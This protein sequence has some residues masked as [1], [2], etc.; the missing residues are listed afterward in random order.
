MESPPMDPLERFLARFDP[1]GASN[2]PSGRGGGAKPSQGQAP[3]YPPP[4]ATPPPGALPPAA[5]PIY[6]PPGGGYGPGHAPGAPPIHPQ[7]ASRAGASGWHGFAPATPQARPGAS[8]VHSAHGAEGFGSEGSPQ[9]PSPGSS[10]GR[11]STAT[12]HMGARIRDTARARVLGFAGKAAS[13]AT[14]ASSAADRARARAKASVASP[15][16][17]PSTADQVKQALR[18][19]AAHVITSDY[20]ALTGDLSRG[21][22]LTDRSDHRLKLFRSLAYLEPGRTYV[23]EFGNTLQRTRADLAVLAGSIEIH[24]SPAAD[25]DFAAAVRALD[26]EASARERA[27]RARAREAERAREREAE[28]AEEARFEA[29]AREREAREEEAREEETRERQPVPADA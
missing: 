20:V 16:A 6:R 5:V 13:L 15:A 4:V 24:I 2:A 26:Q 8:Y 10:A 22:M 1:L 14:A 25:F 17:P 28:A 21:V 23:T 11:S 29:E 27:E 19:N 9:L 7:H 18:V 3:G 12:E